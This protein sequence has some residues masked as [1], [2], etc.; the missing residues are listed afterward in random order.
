MPRKSAEAKRGASG[1]VLTKEDY[2]AID[3]D[4]KDW[5]EAYPW[6][7]K[8]ALRSVLREALELERRMKKIQRWIDEPDRT[9]DERDG[10]AVNLDKMIKNWR[11]MLIS[12]GV[13][14]TSQQLI[15]AKD[16]RA[17]TPEEMLKQLEEKT[18]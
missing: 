8:P 2:D 6:L 15:T 7:A 5:I 12:M 16:R 14:H 1:M 13:T 4:F 9:D 10:A 3:S 18:K 11:A 17:R